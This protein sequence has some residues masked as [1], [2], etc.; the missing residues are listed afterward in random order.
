[1]KTIRSIR[2]VS[3]RPWDVADD[4]VDVEVCLSDGSVYGATFFT[5]GNLESRFEKNSR[6]NEYAGGLYL[7]AADMI[8]VRTLT[9]DAI[10]RTVRDLLSQGDLESAF[11]LLTAQSSVAPEVVQRPYVP[12]VDEDSE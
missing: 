1:M 4:N 7:W 2:V 8:V 12:K 10:E 9:Q 11:S 3:P 6:T 5:L